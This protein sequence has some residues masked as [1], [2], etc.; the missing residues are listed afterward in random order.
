[1]KLNFILFISLLFLSC[2]K[3]LKTKDAYIIEIKKEFQ[4]ILDSARVSGTILI[5]DTQKNAFYS[6]DFKDAKTP[7]LPASTFKIPNSI[8]GL[9][10]EILKDENSVFKWNGEH[11]AMEAWRKDLTLKQAFQ[12]SCVPCYQELARKVG[13]ERM[14]KQLDTLQ[15]GKMDVNPNTIDNFWLIGNSKITPF[16]QIDFLQ[17]LYN[18][19]LSIKPSTFKT[20]I[21][22][23]KIKTTDNYTLSG[24]TGLAVADPTEVGWFVGYVEVDKNVV[25]F[26]TKI[27][28][29]SALP[30]PEFISL[31]KEVTYLALKD[32]DIIN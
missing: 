24:K 8:I 22:I 25:Y 17:R 32:L 3:N 20:L 12:A 29:T 18:N 4:T 6:N 21:S 5:F 10:T 7:Y 15:F 1:M 31:R 19:K 13:V 16:E 30:R 14:N 9:E 11:R 2:S 23:L 27:K 26:A 28:N